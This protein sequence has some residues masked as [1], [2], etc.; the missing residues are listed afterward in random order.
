MP[1]LAIKPDPDDPAKQIPYLHDR[2]TL[3]HW[4]S[5]QVAADTLHEYHARMN[6][7]SIDGLP[8][9]R[10]A[11]TDAGERLWYKDMK[12]RIRKRTRPWEPLLI[13]VI[14]ALLTIIS[15]YMLGLT[16]LDHALGMR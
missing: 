7:V 5:K 1:Y 4:A 3:G 11:R 10:R 6:K 12:S 13:A 2:D 15:M 8:G 14:S 9:L 16:T